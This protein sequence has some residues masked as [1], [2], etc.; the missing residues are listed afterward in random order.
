MSLSYSQTN[1]RDAIWDPLVDDNISNILT[2]QN[3]MNESVREVIGEIDLRSAK[4]RVA[5]SPK[6]FSEEFDYVCPQDMKTLKIID[7]IPQIMKQRTKFSRW[8]LVS[9]EEFDAR[10]YIDKYLCAFS[11]NDLIRRLRAAGPVGLDLFN[12]TIDP[13]SGLTLNGSWSASGDAQNIRVD[14]I[15]YV[16]VPASLEFDIGTGGTGAA[17][18]KNTTLSV[19]DLTNFITQG[20]VFVWIYI[21][22]SSILGQITNVELKIGQDT[23]NY[24]YQT[25]TTDNAQNA[26]AVGWNLLRFDLASSTQTGSPVVTSCQ[27]V[28]LI[29]NSSAAIT[30]V[31]NWRFNWLSAQVGRFH[32]LLYYSK[33]GWQ[34]SSGTW[35]ENS[36]TTT[37]LVVADTDEFELI[38]LKGQ[39]KAAKRIKDY[40]WYKTAQG[41]YQTKMKAYTMSYPSEALLL[42][43]NM[44]DFQKDVDLESRNE[45]FYK[46]D[47]T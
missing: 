46:Y 20:S 30:S 3:I 24:W 22:S 44:Y 21:P 27:Y 42:T 11:D 6:I 36:T 9:Q 43:Q 13:L 5:S 47:N 7:I 10:K 35:K 28:E 2:V 15:N 32:D 17:S 33:Y 18:I 4:R 40:D 37:D 39:M 8:T 26:F 29:I 31:N 1:L 25:V 38:V 45:R 12:Q 23:S 19:F 16:E 14:N 34:S 41:E